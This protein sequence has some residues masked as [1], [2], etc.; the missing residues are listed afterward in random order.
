[1]RSIAPFVLPIAAACSASAAENSGAISLT[2]SWN[3]SIAADGNVTAFNARPNAR[4][5]RAPQ[6][7]ERLEAEIRHWHFLPGTVDGKAQPTETVLSVSISLLPEGE[8]S[9]RIRFDDARTGGRIA[10][11][12]RPHIPKEIMTKHE[13]GV[14]VIRVAYGADGKVTSA[15]LAD[16]SPQKAREIVQATLD[17]VKQWTFEPE[18]VGGHAVAGTHAVPLC[19]TTSVGRPREDELDA[20]CAWRPAGHNTTIAEGD[21]LA[22]EPAARLDT[23][24]AG[25]AL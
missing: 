9:W 18:R 1:M 7:R 20:A 22:L 6:I 10:K 5:D 24:I 8:D 23:A 15:T 25:R 12:T 11:T 21:S 16:D 13:T 17:A 14:V 3:V 2:L 19:Y 4:A